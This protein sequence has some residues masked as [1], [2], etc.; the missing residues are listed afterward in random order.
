MDLPKSIVSIMFSP[1]L[2]GYLI[3]ETEDVSE[4]YNFFKD[5]KYFKGITDITLTDEDINKLVQKEEETLEVKAGDLVRIV[6]GP[7]KGEIAT[8]KSVDDKKK[9]VTV[10]FIQ[11]SVPIQVN[12]KISDVTVIKKEEYESNLKGNS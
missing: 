11:S 12:I 4:L 8:V 9:E 2:R 7:F 6:S 1:K 5:L 3:I 10:A